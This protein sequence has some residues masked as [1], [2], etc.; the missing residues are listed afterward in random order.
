MQ[1]RDIMN[2]TKSSPSFT[3]QPNKKIKNKNLVN[4]YVD[5]T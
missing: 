1:E 5:K 3:P 4:T 2:I